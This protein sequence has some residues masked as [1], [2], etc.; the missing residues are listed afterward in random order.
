[1]NKKVFE[2]N[3]QG[4]HGIKLIACTRLLTNILSGFLVCFVFNKLRAYTC[5]TYYTNKLC[6]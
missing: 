2:N 1:L 4:H 6:V 5:K 3:N